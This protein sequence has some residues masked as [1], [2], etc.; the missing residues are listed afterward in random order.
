M[1]D[2]SVTFER[3]LDDIELYFDY[4]RE[5][6][7]KKKAVYESGE[8]YEGQFWQLEDTLEV[9]REKA[10]RALDEYV[11]S[12]PPAVDSEQVEP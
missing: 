12:R 8:P 2:R 1:S 11:A 10:R 9:L 6:T 3:F 7:Q 5:L 4:K